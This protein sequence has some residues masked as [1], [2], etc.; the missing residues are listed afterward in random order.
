MRGRI[1]AIIAVFFA[2]MAATLGALRLVRRRITLVRVRSASP[3]T[4][5]ASPTTAGSGTATSQSGFGTTSGSG[6]GAA[7]GSAAGATSHKADEAQELDIRDAL[8]EF[9]RAAAPQ[10]FD[11]PDAGDERPNDD[12]SDDPFVTLKS[13]REARA[14]EHTAVIMQG[15]DNE[16]IY[17]TVPV[18][19]V[20]C[21]EGTLHA[22]LSALDALQLNRPNRA[23]L[24]F[25][26]AP[27]GSGVF[28]G[29]GGGS[30]VDGVWIH[31]RLEEAGVLLPALDVIAG[32]KSLG[33][34][35]TLLQP[36]A[37]QS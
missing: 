13:L 9:D 6:F 4:L 26:L 29:L 27:V 28:G 7:S 17:L 24:S 8:D 12:A 19:Y 11:E 5:G 23:G 22:L 30:I 3:P 34:A 18:S 10:A 1:A 25:E 21:D 36:R 37:A 35:R 31:P 14:L 15:G 33:D 20:R 32:R 16:Q 2:V